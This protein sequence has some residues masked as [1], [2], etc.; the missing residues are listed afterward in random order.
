MVSAMRPAPG[1]A[2]SRWDVVN[3]GTLYDM[4]GRVQ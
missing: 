2:L 4:G 3:K 1:G